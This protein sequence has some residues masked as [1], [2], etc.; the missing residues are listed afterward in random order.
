MKICHMGVLGMW[1][2]MKPTS[3]QVNKHFIHR[4]PEDRGPGDSIS[5]S[6]KDPWL[7]GILYGKQKGDT[8]LQVVLQIRV[9][10]KV[11]FVWL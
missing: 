9:S 2:E 7:E 8:C 3:K 4:L 1:T 11:S 10:H 6:S 5:G